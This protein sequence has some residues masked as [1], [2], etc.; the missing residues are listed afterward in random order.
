MP[1]PARKNLRL[2]HFDYRSLTAYFVTICTEGHACVFG[3]VA[4]D[5]M[6]LSQ[7]GQIASECFAAISKHNPHVQV[8]T[9]IVM[10]NHIHAILRFVGATYMSPAGSGPAPKSLSAVIGAFK[11][12]VT[13]EINQRRPGAGAGLWQRSFHDHIIRHDRAY[14]A[15]W[16]YIDD[17][18]RRWF[19][20]EHNP[21]ANQPVGMSHWLEGLT[22]DAGDIY[23]A[24]T[25]KGSP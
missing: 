20:D 22:A 13:R 10:P 4:D 23:V 2:Q 8:D 9:C 25:K 11:A 5:V 6:R 1:L 15:I 16:Q 7:R 12:A 14:D 19:E 24:P 21:Q 17:N 18:P 3:S